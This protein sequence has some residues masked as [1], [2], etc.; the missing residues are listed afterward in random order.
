MLVD[1][2]PHIIDGKT[3]ECKLA[4]PKRDKESDKKKKRK[5]SDLQ[6]PKVGPRDKSPKNQKA[7]ESS[8]PVKRHEAIQ[9]IPT[10]EESKEA[11]PR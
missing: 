6:Q 8:S 1:N 10:K 11:S 9:D 4:V 5:K 7:S 2:L 3:V